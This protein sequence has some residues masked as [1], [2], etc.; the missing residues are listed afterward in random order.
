MGEPPLRSGAED[1]NT[2]DILV[3]GR[4]PPENST[5]A[6]AVKKHSTYTTLHYVHY[7]TIVHTKKEIS[8]RTK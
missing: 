1:G 5:L 8:E 2:N 7:D 6:K 4:N 3:D